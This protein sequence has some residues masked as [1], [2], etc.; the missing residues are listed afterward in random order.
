[1]K[2]ILRFW[3]LACLI[4]SIN[5]H[6]TDYYVNP[7][8]NDEWSGSTKSANPNQ[9]DGPFKT[10]DRAKQAIRGLKK[11]GAYTEKVTVNIAEGIY[12]L[13]HPLHFSLMDTGL[14]DREIIWQGEQGAKVIVSGGIVLNCAKQNTNQWE[15]P[16]PQEPINKDFVDNWRINSNGPKFELYVNQQKLHLARWPD[17]GWAH[18][19]LPLNKDTQFSVMETLPVL[20]GDIKNAQVHIF[21]N[22]DW[23]DVYRVVDSFN[24]ANNSIKLALRT[25]YDLDSGRRFYIENLAVFL[26]LPSEWIYDQASKI[27]RFIPPIGVTPNEIIASSVPNILLIESAKYLS[28]K[29]INFQYSSNS[30]VIITNSENIAMNAVSVNNIGGKGIDIA[31]GQNVQVINSSVHH[32]GSSGIAVSGGDRVTLKSSGHVINNNHIHHMSQ[33]VMTYTPGV[34]VNGVGNTVT[35]NLIEQGPHNA[36]TIAGNEN[37]IEKNEIHHFCLEA[38]DCGAI[39]T[40][41]NWSWRGNII[42]N[43][44]LHDVIGY[45]LQSLDVDKNQVVYTSPFAA[46]AVYLDDGMSGVEISNNIFENAGTEAVFIS[47]GRDNVITNNY[48]KTSLVA[49]YQDGRDESSNQKTLDD[50]P[51]RNSYWQLKYPFLGVPKNNSK[52]PEGN[53]YQRNIIVTDKPDGKSLLYWGPKKSTIIKNNIVWS[54]KGKLLVDYNVMD[55]DKGPQN[56]NTWTQWVAEGIEQGSVVADPCISIL[57]KKLVSCATSP[58]KDI[59]FQPIALDIG[60]LN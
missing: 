38:S 50:S 25:G 8:G 51:Y 47:G 23:Y 60:L 18:I 57:N 59:D 1:M 3:L 45:G 58:I 7:L 36:I 5:A 40:G 21:P 56:G 12:T 44:Y 53:T 24:L 32:T 42:R 46:R 10:L 2:Q 15:C 17:E 54:S 20:K 14:P 26:N 9:T 49:I 31:G 11:T 16:V 28:F 39:Y 30:A 13:T 41:R 43:N 6:A 35:H 19:K 22:S 37:L 48:I 33:V 52:W 55:N 4:I 29:N 27:I 34:E